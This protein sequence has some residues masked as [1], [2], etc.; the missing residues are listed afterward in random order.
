MR[1][2]SHDGTESGAGGPGRNLVL[3]LDGTNNDV[4]SPATNVLRLFRSLVK[5]DEQVCFYDPGV[6][7]L[8]SAAGHWARFKRFAMTLNQAN[9]GDLYRQFENAMVFLA[10]NYR[11]GDRIYLFGFSR[12]AYAARAVAGAIFAMGV[13]KSEHANLVP[14]MWANYSDNAGK[15]DGGTAKSGDRWRGY[16]VFRKSFCREARV[17]LVGVWDTVSAFGPFWRQR[18]LPFTSVNPVFDDALHAI[19]MDERRGAFAVN[20]FGVFD[21]KKHHPR[22]KPPEHQRVREVWFAGVHADVGGGYE[23]EE[24]GL[25]KITLGW[26]VDGAGVCGLR[27]DAAEAER[28]LGLDLKPTKQPPDPVGTMHDELAARAFWRLIQLVPRRAWDILAG[29]RRWR[30]HPFESRREIPEGATVH[31]S[32][33]VR[34]EKRPGEARPALPRR[35]LAEPESSRA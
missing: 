3:C 22:S 5:D 11:E 18:T 6:G 32:D 17:R 34:R 2:M 27:I 1:L 16:N 21:P 13:L 31:A 10:Q 20:T 9:G 14:H 12:G 28:L 30:W 8:P 35:Y 4:T 15:F 24:S 26:M 23:E 33:L 19:A 7:T 25:A 29:E